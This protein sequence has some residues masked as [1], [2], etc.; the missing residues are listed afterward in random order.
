M[1]LKSDKY[2]S[3][4]AVEHLVWDARRAVGEPGWRLVGPELEDFIRH[5]IAGALLTAF[6]KAEALYVNEAF[7][8][9]EQS[10]RTLLEGVL[11]GAK[12]GRASKEA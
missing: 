10:S 9:Q 11:A 8:R 3:S 7:H 1:S 5:E 6:S 2:D 12:L 4:E